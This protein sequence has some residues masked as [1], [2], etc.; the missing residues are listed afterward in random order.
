MLLTCSLRAFGGLAALRM[1]PLG[2]YAP[3]ALFPTREWLDQG[4]LF[5]RAVA[6]NVRLDAVPIRPDVPGDAIRRLEHRGITVYV[7][8]IR[9]GHHQP[10]RALGVIARLDEAGRVFAT[11][12]EAISAARDGLHRAGVLTTVPVGAGPHTVVPG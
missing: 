2:P 12:P 8:G 3:A 1:R 6:R 7:S 4:A 10:L 11:T 9:D 5:L